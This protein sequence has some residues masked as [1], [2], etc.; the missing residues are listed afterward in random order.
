MHR[1]ATIGFLGLLLAVGACAPQVAQGSYKPYS[2]QVEDAH[3]RPLR[4]FRYQGQLFVLGNYGDRYVIRV[5]N[6][7]ARRVEAVVSVDGRDVLSGKP[8]DYQQQR[9]YLVGPHDS[10]RIEGFRKDLGSVAAFRFTTPSDAYSSRMG[11]P[12]NVGV[13]GAAFFPHRRTPPPRYREPVRSAR[14]QAS[15]KGEGSFRG[16]SAPPGSAA[17]GAPPEA[18][19]DSSGAT[20]GG[21]G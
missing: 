13:I 16:Q 1:N 9:G 5:T 2:V 15:P 17:A 3:G 6:H 18:E 19:A 20:L 8:G 21:R 4:S 10:V 7:T 11:T 12:E 14:P